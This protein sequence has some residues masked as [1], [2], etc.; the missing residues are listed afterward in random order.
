MASLGSVAGVGVSAVMP[1]MPDFVSVGKVE[2][3]KSAVFTAF[4]PMA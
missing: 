2:N 1:E 3:L 4:Q